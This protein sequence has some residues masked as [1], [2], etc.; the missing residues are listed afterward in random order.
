MEIRNQLYTIVFCLFFISLFVQSC[1]NG[2]TVNSNPDEEKVMLFER[3][4]EFNSAFEHG[5]VDKLEAMITDKY[6]HTNS[7][8]KSIRKNDWLAYLS[9]RKKELESGKL[10]VNNYKME[11]TEIEIYNDMA[12]VTAK[13]SFSTIK[14]DELKENEI[15]ITNIWVKSWVPRHKNKIRLCT[16]IA[17]NPLTNELLAK[18]I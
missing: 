2:D 5:N 14:S 18:S 7:S 9:K 3:I 6:I 1:K 17:K 15:R 11:E 13:V 4:E 12:I 16:T 10:I 8:S